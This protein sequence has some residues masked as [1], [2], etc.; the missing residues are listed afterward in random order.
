MSVLMAP[1]RLTVSVTDRDHVGGPQTASVTLVE[2][3]DDECPFCGAAYPVVKALQKT[4]GANL[5][6]RHDG[7]YDLESLLGAVRQ[8][9]R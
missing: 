1:P 4:L 5:R 8:Y 9:T 7:G 6:F 2:Y 3:G